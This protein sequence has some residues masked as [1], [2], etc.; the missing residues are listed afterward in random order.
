MQLNNFIELNILQQYF[1]ELSM[2][3]Y[4]VFHNEEYLYLDIYDNI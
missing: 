2:F 1:L 3:K 4:D